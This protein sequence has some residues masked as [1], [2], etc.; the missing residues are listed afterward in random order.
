M[1]VRWCAQGMMGGGIE[2]LCEWFDDKHKLQTGKF[3]PE[4]LEIV[5]D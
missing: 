2:T 5:T 4:S 3:A 1:T